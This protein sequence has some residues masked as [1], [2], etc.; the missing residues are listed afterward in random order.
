MP[1]LPTQS[2]VKKPLPRSIAS[3]RQRTAV[4][5]QWLHIECVA[6]IN[7]LVNACVR[8]SQAYACVYLNPPKILF[9]YVRGFS[10]TKFLSAAPALPCFSVP[11]A[12][13]GQGIFPTEVSTARKRPSKLSSSPPQLNSR[14]DSAF[15]LGKVVAKVLGPRQV[16]FYLAHGTYE[17]DNPFRDV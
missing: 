16:L 9:F 12:N 4:E 13:L 3:A 8:A 14:L 15:K 7:H 17:F 11:F 10:E 5:D 2:R 1:N 6:H